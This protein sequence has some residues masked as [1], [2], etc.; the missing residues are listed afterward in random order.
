MKS[1]SFS[2]CE[3]KYKK[4]EKADYVCIMRS[5]YLR[6][7][8]EIYRQAEDNEHNKSINVNKFALM[9]PSETVLLTRL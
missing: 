6:Q 7:A 5:R 1:Y 4:L 2:G 8:Q 9:D 3:T